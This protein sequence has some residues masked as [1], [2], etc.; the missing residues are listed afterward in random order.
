[1]KEVE[2]ILRVD[3][4][5]EYGAIHIY[6]TQLLIAKL[7]FK[8]IVPTLEEMLI[9]EQ[10]HLR[11]FSDILKRRNIRHCYAL[12]LWA[13]GGCCLGFMT[14]ILGRN[15][16]WVC[17]ESIESTVLHHLDWQLQFLRQHDEEAHN[18][19]FS[20]KSDEEEHRNYG[21]ENGAGSFLYAPI[22]VVVRYSTKV[23]IWL[24]TKL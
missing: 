4:A 18:A 3:H 19:V 8:D 24:S 16:I 1:M 23:A 13:I 11:T 7:C 10:Q 20:I 2:R 6:S 15:A 14:A 21:R 12:K 9:H 22:F 5:G 17:T